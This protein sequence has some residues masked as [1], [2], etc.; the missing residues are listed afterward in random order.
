MSAD[1]IQAIFKLIFNVKGKSLWIQTLNTRLKNSVLRLYAL[2][3]DDLT[4]KVENNYPDF[5]REMI[6]SIN[7]P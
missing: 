7:F 5:Q 4:D 2:F 1:S 3:I 6:E